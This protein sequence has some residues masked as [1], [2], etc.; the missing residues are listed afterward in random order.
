MLVMGRGVME[1]NGGGEGER[2]RRAPATNTAP[3]E[4]MLFMTSEASKLLK[5]KDRC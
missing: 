4:K 5:M 2:T 3:T 1:A